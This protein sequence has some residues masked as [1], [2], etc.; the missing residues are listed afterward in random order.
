MALTLNELYKQSRDPLQQG[1]IANLLRKSDLIGLLP[2]QNT[3]ALRV[4]S[5]RWQADQLPS[6]AHRRI[7]AS[8]T[9][10]TGKTEQVS[11][12]LFILGGEIKIDRVLLMDKSVIEDPITTQTK[13]KTTAM[14]YEFN[15]VA[16]NGD[17]ATDADTPEGM[18]K[19]V[20]NLPSRM[21]IDL[22]SGGD[23]LKVLA[24]TTTENTFIDALHKAVKYVGH[25]SVAGSSGG[26]SDLG[27]TAF[28]MNESTWLGVG[29]ALRRVGLLNTASDQWERSFE[30]FKGARL[31]DCGLKVDQ[32]TEIIL[33]TEDPGDGGDDASSIYVARFNA[34]DAFRGLQLNNLA[35]YEVTGEMETAPQMLRRIDW[36]YGFQQVGQYSL[37]RIKGFKMAAS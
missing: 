12:T 31:V 19:R 35:P 11:E 36:V 4:T 22:A 27:V 37:A 6:V 7:G 32:S 5:T 25:R 18:K 30:T 10:S 29:Q 8:Y 2:F 33:N 13:Q 28:I 16:I 17:H 15:N 26:P 14:A 9:E 34:D 1:I 21:S 24:S 23:A 20:S 3:S